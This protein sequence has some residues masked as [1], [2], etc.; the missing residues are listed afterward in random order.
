MLSCPV[1]PAANIPNEAQACPGC[2]VD[3]T[4]I[5]RVSE[6][7]KTHFNDSLRLAEEGFT[8]DAVGRLMAALALEPRFVMARKLLGKLLWRKGLICEAE[9]HWRQAAAETPEDGEV[10]DLLAAAKKHR[11][12]RTLRRLGITGLGTLAAALLL[13]AAVYVPVNTMGGLVEELSSTVA[14]METYRETHTRT[15]ADF[16]A[17]QL[18]LEVAEASVQRATRTSVEYGEQ[19]TV[20]K[21]QLDETR[22]ALNLEQSLHR[23]TEAQVEQAHEQVG[24]LR[25]ELEQVASRL[26]EAVCFNRDEIQAAQACINE[27]NR[28]LEVQRGILRGL[29]IHFGNAVMPLVEALRPSDADD[30]RIKIAQLTDKLDNLRARRDK[31]RKRNAFL[32]DALN[33]DSLDRKIRRTEAKLSVAQQEYD[34]RVVPWQQALQALKDGLS[35]QPETAKAAPAE[36]K[37]SGKR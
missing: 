16:M 11:R 9:S 14:R 33:V 25:N 20:Y 17:L 32:I 3:L 31:C 23:K 37:V 1:C 10:K 12:R 19:A 7:A 22:A 15:D 6:L 27:Q 30:L 2:G 35:S 21:R 13:S 34:A 26:F 8:D 24:A 29:R 18:E 4:P 28:E 36:G 5:H